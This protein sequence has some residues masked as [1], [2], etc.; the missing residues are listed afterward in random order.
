MFSAY[1]RERYIY[2]TRWLEAEIGAKT[3]INNVILKKSISRM[4]DL[5]PIPSNYFPFCRES[6]MNHLYGLEK[7]FSPEKWKPPPYYIGVYGYLYQ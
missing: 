3:H 6:E 2:P 5:F 1:R 4:I 7:S